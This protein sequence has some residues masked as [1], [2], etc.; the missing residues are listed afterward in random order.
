MKINAIVAVSI[1]GVIGANGGI[2]WKSP[3]DMRRFRRL[4]LGGTVIMGRET[5]ESIGLEPLSQRFNIVL[6]K[7]QSLLRKPHSKDNLVFVDSIDEAIKHVPHG[8]EVWVIGGTSVYRQFFA[9]NLVDCVHATLILNVVKGDT[10]FPWQNIP[11]G[12]KLL[13]VQLS[14]D[15]N[16]QFIAVVLERCADV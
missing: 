16:P 5:Y 7:D 3:E 12:W 11:M 8:N 14:T 6:T 10:V 2:P 13:G 15:C 1:N 9:L 4:T